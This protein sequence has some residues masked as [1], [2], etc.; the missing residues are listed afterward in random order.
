M[1][2]GH[3]EEGKKSGVGELYY[4]N[5]DKFSGLWVDDKATGSGVLE[6]SNGDN[7]DGTIYIYVFIYM[8]MYV[9]LLRI[10]DIW[11]CGE[12]R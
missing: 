3:W 5:G 8:Y 7:Y 4:V 1:Y 2:V 11:V 9:C 12:L 10:F 6:Y